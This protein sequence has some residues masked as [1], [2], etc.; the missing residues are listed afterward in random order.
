MSFDGIT[1][2]AKAVPLQRICTPLRASH[3][4]VHIE[5]AQSEIF[6][7]GTH[8]YLECEDIAR[9]GWAS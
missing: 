1:V 6:Q 4:F 9:C 3:L 2:L 7:C 8:V 5:Q